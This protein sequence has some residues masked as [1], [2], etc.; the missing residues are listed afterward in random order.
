MDKKLG[1]YAFLVVVALAILAGL[2]PTLQANATVTWV[3]LLL[4][5]IVGLMNITKKET[6]G[7]LVASIALMLVGG[8]LPNLGVFLA[9]ILGNIVA[10]V[11][12]AALVVSLKAVYDYAQKK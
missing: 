2:V 3:L 11:A 9:A 6:S 5:L 4:G 7:F 10:F 12:P 1:S 8:V